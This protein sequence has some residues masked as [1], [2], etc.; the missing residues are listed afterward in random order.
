[1]Q[2]LEEPNIVEFLAIAR[3]GDLVR[4]KLRSESI[5][6]LG[7]EQKLLSALLLIIRLLEHR[8]TSPFKQL[9]PIDFPER[10]WHITYSAM[11]TSR[12]VLT[13]SEILHYNCLDNNVP[14]L[15]Q[16]NNTVSQ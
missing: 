13:S 3:L 7:T 2:W 8:P 10:D 16:H 9:V 11:A 14:I 6:L 1:M 5:L 15:V 4:W 12:W